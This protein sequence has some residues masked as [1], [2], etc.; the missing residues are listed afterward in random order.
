MSKDEVKDSA[1]LADDFDQEEEP[2]KTGK[3][4]NGTKKDRPAGVKDD[5][6]EPSAI[7]YFHTMLLFFGR[8][9][10]KLL[11]LYN[12]LFDLAPQDKTKIYRNISAYYANKGLHEKALEYLKEW[13]RLEPSNPD[14]FFQLALA[15]AAAG[16]SK[17]AIGAFAKVLKL[18]PQHKAALY[19]KSGLHLK[20]KDYD[21]A[22]EGLENLVKVSPDKA[23][24]HYLLGIAYD[25]KERL[26]D[27]IAA[28]QKAIELDGEE[29]KFYQHLGFLYE[30]TE[31]HKEAARCFSKVMELEREHEDD[32]EE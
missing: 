23:E 6:S 5:S 25:R 13:T 3:I 18:N 19:R 4:K 30:R 16:N 2:R 10:G 12:S 1:F 28:I 31:N 15:L 14:A 29:V 21:Q 7:F 17:S 22:I 8:L 9:F 32:E 24:V 27:A 26:D 11:D 20:L